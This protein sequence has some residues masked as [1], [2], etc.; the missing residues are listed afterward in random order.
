M[1]VMLTSLPDGRSDGAR[2]GRGRP[3]GAALRL[4]PQGQREDG[5]QLPARHTRLQRRRTHER[6]FQSPSYD[7]QSRVQKCFRTTAQSQ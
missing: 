7:W 1:E 3:A 2:P 6:E 5:A 4:R